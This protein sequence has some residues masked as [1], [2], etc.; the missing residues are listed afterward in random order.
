MTTTEMQGTDRAWEMEIRPFQAK[1]PVDIVQI[2][3][4]LGLK[5]W[6]EKMPENISGM[7]KRD[8]R[9]G[10]SSG[11]SIVVNPSHARTRQRFTI[12]HEIAH[13]LL[14]RDRIGD[15]IEDDVLMRSGLS[16][17]EE[18][19]ANKLAARIL[20]PIHLIRREMNAGVRTVPD[21]ARRFD[22]SAQAMSI[23]LDLP[24]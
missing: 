1:A 17:L 3:D 16:N 11:Y 7:I 2:A 18:I 22:V 12:A 19:Q 14:H 21:L 10:G 4:R 9:L 24:F 5:V 15:G 13:Y 23:R 20:M 6:K 8:S